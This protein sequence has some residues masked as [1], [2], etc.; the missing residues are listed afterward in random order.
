MTDQQ[1]VTLSG[2]QFTQLLQ[3]LSTDGNAGGEWRIKIREACETVSRRRRRRQCIGLGHSQE[4]DLLLFSNAGHVS[5]S[6]ISYNKKEQFY[7]YKQFENIQ[8]YTP[9]PNPM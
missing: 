8:T 2:D 9:F 6:I 7:R 3:R 1:P 4:L 5:I